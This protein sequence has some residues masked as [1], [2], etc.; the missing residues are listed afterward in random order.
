MPIHTDLGRLVPDFK[1]KVTK[2]LSDMTHDDTLKS[3]GVQTVTVIETIRDLST[4]MAYFSRGRMDAADVKLMYKAAGLWKITTDDAG[5]V[6]TWTLDSKHLSG[7]AVDIAPMRAGAV[8]WNAPQIVWE[9]IGK[10]AE[11]N[12]LAWGGRW[13]TSDCPHV[14]RIPE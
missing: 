6:I 10:I 14:E 8:W 2:A 13:K 9:R 11:D 3:M 1:H 5:K 4:Q 12:G 7:E